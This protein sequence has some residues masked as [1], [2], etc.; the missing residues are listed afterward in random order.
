MRE[1]WWLILGRTRLRLTSADP[2]RTLR[3]M[4]Q[5]LRLEDVHRVS[6]LVVEFTVSR[7]DLKKVTNVADRYGDR[8]EILKREGFPQTVE[9]WLR[10]PVICLTM[11]GLILAS[12]WLPSRVLF[13]RVEGNESIPRRQ[14]LE[15]ASTCGLYFGAARAEVRSEQLKNRL[16]EAFPELSWVG[17]NTSGSMATITVQER[18]REPEEEP[19]L[20]G[21]I[22]ASADGI[23][24]A[25]TATTGTPLCAVGEG[26]RAGQTLISGYTDLG[27]CTHVEAAEGEVFA[28][29]ERKTAAVLPRK[30]LSRFG[31]TETVKKYSLLLGKNRINFYSDSGILY[32][33][34]GKMTKIRV[35]TLPGGWTVPAALIVEEY[36]VSETVSTERYPEE[37]QSMLETAARGVL[38]QTMIAGEIR[39]AESAFEE[40]EETYRL[41]LLCRCHE[42]IGRRSSGI[43][44]EGDTNDG[45]N[46]ERGTG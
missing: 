8:L 19:L 2:E 22:V 31:E 45:E 21:N 30:T 28:L 12:L 13:F 11:V 27:L 41:T 26:V 32:T 20:P 5:E 7:T 29:T 42:M 18:Q 46:G 23:V 39:S 14:I 40:L 33:G 36:A 16:L 10:Y 24:T 4:T 38:E 17:V 37:A 9:N 6:H 44:T 43:L 3:K 34:C 15:E 35:L 1:L 25:I